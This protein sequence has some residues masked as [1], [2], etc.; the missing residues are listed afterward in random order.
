LAN[1]SFREKNTFEELFGMSS[2]YV[3]DF[4]NSS[5][6]RFIGDVVNIDIYNGTGYTEYSSKANK[7]RQIW[8]D[9]PDNV[10][11]TLMDAMLSYY[12]DLQLRISELSEYQKK[13]VGEMRVV[14]QRLVGNDMKISF[15][16]KQEETLQTLLEDINSSLSRNQPTLVLDRLHTFSTKLLRQMCTDNG[17]TVTD[18]KGR[19]LPLHS[20][21]GLL[22]KHY[23]KIS[24]FQSS[25][26]I[27]A[28]QNSIS[29]FDEYNRIRNDQSYAHDNDV[30]GTME[31]EFVVKAMANLI[32]FIDKVE[33]FRKKKGEEAA[34]IDKDD[35][36]F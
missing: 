21:A 25:F 6:A 34:I 7:L 12:E 9:E 32:F 16:Q 29:L 14:C 18:D 11:G 2:G 28:V 8:T 36:P 33:A 13:K 17:L 30:L 22:K 10:V 27:L 20:L 15:P 19:Y 26:T 24:I 1:L 35:I 3:L 5:F 23:E 31:S 4:S